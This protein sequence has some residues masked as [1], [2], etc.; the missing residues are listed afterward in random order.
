MNYPT[1]RIGGA[2]L[3]ADTLDRIEKGDLRGQKPADFGLEAAV[4]N[5]IG[6]AWA[7]VQDMWRIYQMPY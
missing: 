1:I 7:D 2:I 6:R 3:S 5:K 4:K